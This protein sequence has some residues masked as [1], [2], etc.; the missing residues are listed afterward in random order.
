MFFTFSQRKL[1]I[2]LLFIFF[3]SFP[4][5]TALL[6]PGL[7]PHSL[8]DLVEPLMPAVVSISTTCI[9]RK[10]GE[11]QAPLNI[12]VPKVHLIE[13]FLRDL[14]EKMQAEEYVSY[15]GSGFIFDNKGHILTTNHLIEDADQIIVIL[16]DN[17][18]LVATLVG[19]DSL[20]DIAVL[21][22]QS[23]KTLSFIPWGESEKLRT[24][25]P[26]IAIGNP[27]GLGGTVTSGIVSYLAREFRRE[28]NFIPEYIQTDAAI[29]PGSSG[30][31]LC[32]MN[33]KVVGI[34][35]SVYS[36]S[37]ENAGVGFS[38]PSE[39]AKKVVLQILQYGRV[40]RGYLGINT[41]VITEDIAESLGLQNLKGALVCGV[42]KNGPAAA[43]RFRTGDVI[44]KL[45]NEEIKDQR[46]FLRVME[47][48]PI[49]SQVSAV[50]FRKGKIL[51]LPIQVEEAMDSRA[52]SLPE[53][54]KELTRGEEI[55]GMILQ[56]LTGDTRKQFGISCDIQGILVIDVEPKSS[57]AKK[58][59]RLGDII[60]EINQE[61]TTNLR[62]AIALLKKLEK[63]EKK[64]ILL[65]INRY[66]EPL[67]ISVP[68][69][70][71]KND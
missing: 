22:I 37:G 43:A 38:I 51:S 30:G 23:N 17:T 8:A 15:T 35:T 40:K 25:D 44:L 50:I 21:K 47:D 55:Y 14:F 70:T 28:N 48:L 62:Q 26:V 66:G 19:R 63:Q 57:A 27:F 68:I 5:R 34:N 69:F 65:L 58:G 45:G 52:V 71:N 54:E 7:T 9:Y 4:I 10:Q 33:G 53:T 56:D 1:I 24:G 18:E 31:P 42:I 12:P 46:N 60:L 61:Q 3:I 59:I 36:L 41:Q 49:G 2:F 39:T 6:D 11:T 16:N 67:Y 13:E 29:N 20:T 64:R 32:D